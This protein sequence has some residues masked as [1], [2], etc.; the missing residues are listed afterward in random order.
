MPAWFKKITPN[1]NQINA[2]LLARYKEEEGTK[3]QYDASMLYHN[4]LINLCSK[5]VTKRLQE[6]QNIDKK[7]LIGTCL[8][9]GACG[10]SFIFPMG[11]LVTAGL[12]YTAYQ[13]GLRQNAYKNYEDALRNIA[14]S[15]VWS[16]GHVAAKFMQSH[17]PLNDM[18]KVMRPLFNEQQLRDY[19]DDK[20]EDIFIQR[21]DKDAKDVTVMDHKLDEQEKNLFSKVYGFEQGGVAAILEGIGHVIAN[22]VSRLQAAIMPAVEKIAEEALTDQVQASTTASP[23]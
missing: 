14:N 20:Y 3:G 18:M 11:I 10:L 15:C 19:I 17:A 4:D 23:K 8:T 7:I 1:Q 16:L 12:A 2:D 22:T 5:E 13:F 6:L 9:L 21:A